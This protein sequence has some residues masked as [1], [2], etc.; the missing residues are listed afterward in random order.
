MADDIATSERVRVLRDPATYGLDDRV[1]EV[2]ETSKSWVFLTPTEVYKLK[3]PVRNH[4]QDLSTIEA[5][6]A[7][8]MSE[9]RLNRRLAPDVYLDAVSLTRDDWGDLHLDGDG[10]VVDWL[11]RMRRLPEDRMLD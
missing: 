5:R 7:N 6:A 4:F 11:V 9:I 2:K 3:K 1:I 8:T 10:H